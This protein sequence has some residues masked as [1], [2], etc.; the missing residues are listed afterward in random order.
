[1]QFDNDEENRKGFQNHYT[2]MKV[3]NSPLFRTVR[4]KEGW[5]QK[6]LHDFEERTD[7]REGS[8][9]VLREEKRRAQAI[10]PH[11]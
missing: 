7:R 11:S 6:S 9:T 3:P 10:H 4:I 1:M 2:M 8:D 5:R